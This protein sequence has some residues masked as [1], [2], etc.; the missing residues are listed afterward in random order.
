MPLPL[1]VLGCAV[2]P[3]GL[4]GAAARRVAEAA[5]AYHQDPRRLVVVSGGRVWHE[6]V[7]ADAMAEALVAAGVLASRILRERCS[8]S[9]RENA[10][11]SARLLARRD[12]RA[13][14]LVTCTWHMA[15]AAALFRREGLEVTE[16][17]AHAPTRSVWESLY[18]RAR[19]GVA[20]RLNGVGS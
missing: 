2:P 15:R 5:S 16:R 4:T 7:E 1:V 17:G 6:R 8:F 13:V 12:H 9:T 19:E 10:R 18:R 14:E 20:A 11:Y 3:S